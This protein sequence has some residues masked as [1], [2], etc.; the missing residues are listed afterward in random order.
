MRLMERIE[1]R[2]AMGKTGP[3]TYHVARAQLS[4]KDGRIFHAEVKIALGEAANPLPRSF[5][6]EKFIKL[7]ERSEAT[8]HSP[9][10][11]LF[12]A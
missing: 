9:C 5:L 7:A 12:P 1:L 3:S 2:P 8:V 4:L 6:E 10:R 11:R